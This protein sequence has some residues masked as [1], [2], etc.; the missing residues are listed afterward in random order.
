MESAEAFYAARRQFGGVTQ[1]KEELRERRALPPIDVLFQDVR[2]AFR[3]LRNAK[4]FTAS[5][6]ITLALGIATIAAS[7]S[8]RFVIRLPR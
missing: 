8:V 4:K 7:R 3:Q 2:Y 6:A 5:A 1:M